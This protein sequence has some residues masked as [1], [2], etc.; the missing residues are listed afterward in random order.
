MASLHA[1]HS[2]ESSYRIRNRYLSKLGIMPEDPNRERKPIRK[3]RGT[4][5]VGKRTSTGEGCPLVE[6]MPEISL[7]G[8]AFV[9]SG[10]STSSLTYEDE[11]D[12]SS[13]YDESDQEEC[14]IDTTEVSCERRVE[15]ISR[16]SFHTS[17][18]VYE[19][20]SH[21]DYDED[22]HSSLWTSFDVQ[23]KNAKRNSFEYQADQKDWRNACEEDGMVQIQTGEFVHPATWRLICVHMAAQR[24]H[25][26]RVQKATA[27]QEP[28]TQSSRKKSA[29]LNQAELARKRLACAARSSAPSLTRFA[30]T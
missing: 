12:E 11:D 7:K 27:R 20:P 16:V 15:N 29:A 19:I 4:I 3:L 10:H 13:F 24:L 8:L 6:E 18:S 30:D 23:T 5:S 2:S 21:R 17:V 22:S 9:E 1:N 25:G 28:P 26:V 14:E